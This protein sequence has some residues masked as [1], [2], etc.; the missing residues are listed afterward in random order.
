[1]ISRD[2]VIPQHRSELDTH[3]HGFAKR[4]PAL[5]AAPAEPPLAPH[6][7]HGVPGR[8]RR[9]P[10][11]LCLVRDPGRRQAHCP[12]KARQVQPAL[13]RLAA[14]ARRRSAASTLQPAHD[15]GRDQG[16][17]PA[18]LPGHNGDAGLV[19]A[20]VLAQQDAAYVYN[21]G[22]QKKE[23]RFYN[24]NHSIGKEEGEEEANKFRAPSLP[25][26]STPSS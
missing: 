11:K 15:R 20:L 12:R 13:A 26:A 22:E 4:H 17:R 10:R 19:A 5:P 16:P 24:F 21:N 9:R 2:T 3:N 8:R 6:P 23:A 14:Q 7:R 25:W 18:R 1:M